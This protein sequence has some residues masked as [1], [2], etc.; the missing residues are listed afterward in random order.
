MPRPAPV[1][2]ATL[3][4]SIPMT[5]PPALRGFF[6]SGLGEARIRGASIAWQA[7]GPLGNDVAQDL[8]RPRCDRLRPAG[9]E[10]VLP[11]IGRVAV[12]VGADQRV[13]AHHVHGD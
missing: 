9:Q 1:T 10:D 6:S 8:A 7:Q 4:S 13:G 2:T 12:A 5:S 3:P 11:A